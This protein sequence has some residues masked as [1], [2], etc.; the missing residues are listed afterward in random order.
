MFW[1][2]VLPLAGI[3]WSGTALMNRHHLVRHSADEKEAAPKAIIR[4]AFRSAV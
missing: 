4:Q 3:I 2:T 1:V